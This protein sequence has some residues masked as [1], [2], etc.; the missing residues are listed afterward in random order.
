VCDGILRARFRRS[1]ERPA[2][3]E[4]GVV[5]RYVIDMAATSMVF[6]AGHCLAVLVTSSDFPRHDVN[7]NTGVWPAE[8]VLGEPARQHIALDADR[9]S[10]VLLPVMQ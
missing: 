6:P 4:P 10:H 7:P 1:L 5:E 9:A 8:A 3:V 2:L